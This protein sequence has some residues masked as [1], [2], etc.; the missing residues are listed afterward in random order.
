MTEIFGLKITSDPNTPN[1]ARVQ[2]I[3]FDLEN[4][5]LGKYALPG[6]LISQGMYEDLQMPWQVSPQ[7]EAFHENDLRRREWNR[8]GRLENDESDFFIGYSTSVNKMRNG[9]SSASMYTRWA[10]A[11]P[12]LAGTEEDCVK[13]QARRIQEATQLGDDDELKVGTAVVL[14]LFKRS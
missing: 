1:A 14:L 11:N 5:V 7:V 4:N 13:V 8:D 9:I 3:M 2:E 10:A 6:N 12:H